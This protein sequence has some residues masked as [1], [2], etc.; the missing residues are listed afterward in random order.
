MNFAIGQEV[1][2]K[3]I[4]ADGHCDYGVGII[5]KI[6]PECVRYR[7][8]VLFEDNFEMLFREEEIFDPRVSN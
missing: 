5:T 3:L 8:L 4:D 6:M 2:V 1:Y 7:Y